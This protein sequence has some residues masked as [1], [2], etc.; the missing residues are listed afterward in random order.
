MKRGLLRGK[1]GAPEI[2]ARVLSRELKTLTQ[3]GV[4]R[5]IDHKQVPPDGASLIPVIKVVHDWSVEHLNGEAPES[6]T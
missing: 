2:A 5:R 1:T 6:Q 3:M 4:V